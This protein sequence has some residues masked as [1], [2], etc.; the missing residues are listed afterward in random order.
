MRDLPKR[1]SRDS[2]DTVGDSQVSAWQVQLGKQGLSGPS[3][4]QP[5]A[6]CY[7]ARQ[8]NQRPQL[9]M[10]AFPKRKL[11]TALL[12]AVL[13]E[14]IVQSEGARATKLDYHDTPL[15]CTVTTTS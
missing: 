2:V 15:R 10:Q 5:L 3:Q 12:A 1:S 13:L 11:W 9:M 8:W 14:L 4:L 6:L 7:L